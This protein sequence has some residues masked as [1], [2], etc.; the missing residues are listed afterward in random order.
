MESQL[1]ERCKHL[2]T[3]LIILQNTKIKLETIEGQL[4]EYQNENHKL[5]IRGATVFSELTP[6]YDKFRD[7]FGEFGIKADFGSEAQNIKKTQ[8]RKSSKLVVP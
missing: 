3:T 7:V 6:R 1:K 8:E 5:A 2:E 4:K